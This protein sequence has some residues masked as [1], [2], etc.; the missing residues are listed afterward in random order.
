MSSTSACRLALSLALIGSGVATHGCRPQPETIGRLPTGTDADDTF[1]SSGDVD[2]TSGD[3]GAT[4]ATSTQDVPQTTVTIRVRATATPVVHD[5]PWSG[6][7]PRDYFAGIRSLTLIDESGQDPDLLVFDLSP[8]HVEAGWNDGDE[9]TVAQLPVESLTYGT[10]T[11]ARVA[12][13]HLRFTVD[14]TVHAMGLSAAGEVQATQVLSDGTMLDGQVRDRGWWRYVFNFA[15]MQFPTGGESGAP[16]T[17]PPAGG[18]IEVVVEGDE[19]VVYFPASVLIDPTVQNDV[20]AVLEV[21][22]HEAFRWQDLD[23]PEYAPGVFDA[24]PPA[25]EPIRQLGV[26][27][28]T[29]GFD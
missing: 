22:V 27:S 20:S 21:N 13:S 9:T 4:E 14:T 3:T 25:F 23:E 5:D 24:S 2:D 1:S 19:T 7:T 17:E 15:G 16:V 18:A 10:F 11:R 6:Q 28:Y 12:V 29:L 26:N 8:D